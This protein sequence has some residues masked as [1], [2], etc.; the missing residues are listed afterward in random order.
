MTATIYDLTELHDLIEAE[1]ERTEGELSPELEAALTNWGADFD[2][3]VEDYA[4]V[5]C[6]QKALAEAIEAEAKKLTARAASRL[7]L[8]KRLTERLQQNMEAVGKTEVRGVLKTVKIQV[9]PPSVL[10]VVPTDAPDF[11]NLVMIA[12]DFVTHTPE[13]YSW[14]RNAIKAA[15]KAGTLPAEVEKRVT[16]VASRSI[17]IR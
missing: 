8:A 13:S 16:L 3:K 12:P 7:N 5:I 11:R 1:L 14:N 17:R 9:N 10:E 4:L 6:E 2:R 15:A